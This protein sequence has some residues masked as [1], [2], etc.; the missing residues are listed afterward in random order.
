[1]LGEEVVSL[2]SYADD[3]GNTILYD[4][5]RNPNVRVRFRGSNCVV[6]VHHSCHV[7]SLVVDFN[8]DNGVFELGS[9]TAR[10][11][12]SASVRVGQDAKVRIGD[13]VSSTAGVVISAVEGAE[14]SIGNDVMFASENQLRADDGH[15]IFDVRTGR[16]VNWSRDVV[17]GDHVW[18]AWGAVALGGATIGSGSVLGLR[19]VL[20]GAVPNNCVAVGVPARVVRRDIAWERPH[21]GMNRPFYKPVSTAVDID[22][23]YWRLTRDDAN[24]EPDAYER[25]VTALHRAPSRV[26][27]TL[28]KVRE[29]DARSLFGGS[30]FYA[31]LV[32]IDGEGFLESGAFVENVGFLGD[33]PRKF[34]PIPLE[35]RIWRDVVACPG[36]L[37]IH[38]K[39]VLPDSFRRTIGVNPRSRWLPSIDSELARRPRIVPEDPSELPLEVRPT[40][41]LDSEHS[42]TYGHLPTEVMS[43]LWC[44]DDLR[45][46]FDDLQFA[47]SARPGEDFPEW[48]YTLLSGCGISR[49]EIVVINKPTRFLRMLAATPALSLSQYVHSAALRVWKNASDALSDGSYFGESIFVSRSAGLVRPCRNQS[50]VETWFARHGFEVVYPETLSIEA[51]V[52]MFRS[53]KRI[54]GFGGSGLLNVVFASGCS[55]DLLVINSK[56]YGTWTEYLIRKLNPGKVA[57]YW[58]DSEV[59]HP[60]GGWSLEAFESGF[61]VDM[62]NAEPFFENW[63]S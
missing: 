7:N 58:C 30:D 19:S 15:P 25:L 35:A 55:S 41:A 24:D 26:P 27:P 13:D 61:S 37:L 1:M 43:R 48:G 36:Q 8:A 22:E 42:A 14:V 4:G 46:R 2:E 20:T 12:F 9:N 50:V 5:P 31:P 32:N 56:S 34:S 17:V 6:R 63:L 3:R 54:A 51:Q 49:D 33:R 29:E 59:D 28:R 16:R 53:A 10:R 40:L 62:K 52:S 60:N 18:F 57:Y 44:L 39:W 23:R 21:L 45:R 38:G 11:T 47:V